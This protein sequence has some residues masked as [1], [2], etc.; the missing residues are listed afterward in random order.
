MSFSLS[1]F[2]LAS[3]FPPIAPLFSPEAM[4]V[5]SVTLACLGLAV[6]LVTRSR[7]QEADPDDAFPIGESP[8]DEGRT[9]AASPTTI[10][11]SPAAEARASCPALLDAQLTQPS[12]APAPTPVV[13]PLHLEAA[14]PE[15]SSS[16]PIP[17]RSRATKDL[18]ERAHSRPLASPAT[19]S[20][21]ARGASA[22]IAKA[23]QLIPKVFAPPAAEDSHRGAARS[24]ASFQPGGRFSRSQQAFLRIPV[25]LTGSDESGAA[26]REDSSTLI[27]LPQ[28]AVIPMKQHVAAG[29]RLVLFNSSRQQEVDCT[30]FGAHQGPD[31]KMLVEVEFTEMQ[32]NLWPVSFPAWARPGSGPGSA[33]ADAPARNPALNGSRP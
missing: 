9:G 32:R 13:A 24:A 30:V 2:L 19:A 21:P 33:S 20:A 16:G 4:L 17:A 23:V 12:A 1:A 26:F 15:G 8:F 14:H 29:D 18:Q 25:V 27:L 5:T 10:E 28:G 22:L 6:M 7:A 11:F 3:D 31:G